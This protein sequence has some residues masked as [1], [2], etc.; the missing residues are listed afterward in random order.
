MTD[1]RGQDQYLAAQRYDEWH[2]EFLGNPDTRLQLA[3]KK[4]CG[5]EL[6]TPAT[7]NLFQMIYFMRVPRRASN[8]NRGHYYRA[9]DERPWYFD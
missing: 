9:D 8:E 3:L 2:V 4:R 5:L 7:F 6:Y 1:F